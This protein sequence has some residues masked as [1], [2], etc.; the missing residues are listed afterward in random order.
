[1]DLLPRPSLTATGWSQIPALKWLASR[2]LCC[3]L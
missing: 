1:V 3:L 2:Q